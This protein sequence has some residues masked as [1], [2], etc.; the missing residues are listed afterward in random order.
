M[1]NKLENY[2]KRDIGG[3]IY[4]RQ[5]K[6]L[7]GYSGP[8]GTYSNQTIYKI[9]DKKDTVFLREF[10]LRNDHHFVFINSQNYF[11]ISNLDT[12]YWVVGQK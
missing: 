4:Y 7:T 6:L 1:V 10:H 5:T 9:T 8:G 11:R 2:A 3:H 12:P